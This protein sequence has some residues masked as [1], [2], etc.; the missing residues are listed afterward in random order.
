MFKDDGLN[1]EIGDIDNNSTSIL[2]QSVL[3]GA[4][5]M[6]QKLFEELADID[7]EIEEF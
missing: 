3:K 1:Y 4:K 2:Q 5:E 6:R 7:E